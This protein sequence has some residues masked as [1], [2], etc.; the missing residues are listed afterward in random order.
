M[1]KAWKLYVQTPLFVFLPKAFLFPSIWHFKEDNLVRGRE[2]RSWEPS[3]FG[4]K[5]VFSLGNCFVSKVRPVIRDYA[6][7]L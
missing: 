7:N 4:A 3:D 5:S 6:L 1:E 2:M